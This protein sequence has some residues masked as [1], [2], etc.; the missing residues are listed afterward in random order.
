MLALAGRGQRGSNWA[1]LIAV[2]GGR[3]IGGGVCELRGSFQEDAQLH[4]LA[5][6]DKTI[7]R[8]RRNHRMEPEGMGRLGAL[9]PVQSSR[10]RKPVN[11]SG[12][13]FLQ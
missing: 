10:T 7:R 4:P 2:T 8:S 12:V 1:S 9:F 13:L 3:T 11:L 5:F 6:G